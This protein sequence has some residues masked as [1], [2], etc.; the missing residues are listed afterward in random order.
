M[1]SSMFSLYLSHTLL[2]IVSA[3]SELITV[4]VGSP[5]A[6]FRI[7]ASMLCASSD[8]MRARKKPEW[9]QGGITIKLPDHPSYAFDLY[10]NWLY[11]R[12]IL[13]TSDPASLEENEKEFATLAAAYTLGEAI[14]DTAFKDTIIDA[15]RAKIRPTPSPYIWHFGG[16]IIR[17]IYE[18]TPEGSMARAFLVNLYTSHAS[19]DDLTSATVEAPKDFYVDVAVALRKRTETKPTPCFPNTKHSMCLYHSHG[20]EQPCYLVQPYSSFEDKID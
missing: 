12:K 8:F 13:T 11:M 10:A 15:L 18:G 3:D 4:E 20:K 2:T 17:T 16:E 7:H 14:L 6:W 9:S 5:P 1:H 19:E